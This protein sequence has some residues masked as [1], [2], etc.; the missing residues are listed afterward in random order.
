VSTK[1]K[2]TIGIIGAGLIG[3]SIAKASVVAGYGTIVYDIDDTIINDL[4]KCSIGFAHSPEVLVKHAD[5]IFIAVP[6]GAFETT[7][8]NIIPHLSAGQIVTDVSSTKQSP[9]AALAT[10]PKGVIV[11]G[12]HPMAGTEKAGFKNSNPDM[13][14]DCIWVLCP[15]DGNTV[16]NELIRFVTEIGAGRTI[17]CT[18]EEHDIAVANISHGVQVSSSSLAAAIHDIAGSNELSWLLASGGFRDTTRI[19]ESSPEMWVPILEENSDNII[20]VIEADIKRLGRFLEALKVKDSA[21]I[22]ELIEDGH[23]ARNKWKESKNSN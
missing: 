16:P 3:G 21:E 8:Q 6:V 13:F 1:I 19:A 22:K 11:V 15:P 9:V 17:I 5:I 20:K 18:P 2:P 10:A 23:K 4:I 14:K 12:G 7:L